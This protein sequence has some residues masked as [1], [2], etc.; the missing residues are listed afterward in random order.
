MQRVRAAL[1]AAGLS[2]E[3]A[4]ERTWEHPEPGFPDHLLTE[5]PYQTRMREAA[6]RK[7]NCLLHGATGAGKTAVLYSLL[8]RLK[9]RS[10]VMVWTG[11]LL[12]QWRERA[13]REF[14]LT[15]R[16]VGIIQGTREWIRPLTI[17][18]Q[19]TIAAR[20]EH[21]DD[22]LVDQFDVLAC[23]EVQ[24]M[25][26]RTCQAAVD[27]FRARYRIGVSADSSRHD[28]LE[29]LIHDLF[30]D[31]AEEITEEETIA[32]GATVDVE[33]YAVPTNFRAPWYRYRQ[34]FNK[35]LAQM[36]A[37]EER[38]ELAL[39]IARQEVEQG[40]QVL[41]FTHRVEH[42]LALDSRLT[43]FGIR[44]GC[45][46]GGA[47]NREAFRL[48]ADGFR[49]GTHRA[50][51]GTY[52]A[53]AQGIDLPTVSRGVCTTP[54]HNNRQHLSQVKG[55]ICRG[56]DGKEFGRLYVLVDQHVYGRKPVQNF[57]KW[58]RTVRVF[59][60]ESWIDGKEW[61]R[62]QRAA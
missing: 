26:A 49:A 34:D 62:M 21:G 1:S 42:A 58:F 23:D 56:A 27:P 31:V 46:L 25:A 48:A 7:Q 59:D 12:D 22:S 24:R 33:V 28:R 51:V 6:E 55:R 36:T 4:D 44:S 35:L 60:G 19:Q 54:M 13:Q 2:W 15:E 45:M 9:R 47:D 3:V 50:G 41:L 29:C 17:C 52:Q 16:E 53:I 20:F 11:G 37:D 30:G 39:R 18:M 10:L 57:V 14:D 8:S 32:A 5:R 38:N 61:L 43:E 40:E